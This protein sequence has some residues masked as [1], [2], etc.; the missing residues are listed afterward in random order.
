MKENNNLSFG[1]RVVYIAQSV[2][3]VI[4]LV[5]QAVIAFNAVFTPHHEF[6]DGLVVCIVENIIPVVIFA[7]LFIYA[8]FGLKKDSKL[9]YAIAILN[10]VYATA[11]IESAQA[12]FAVARPILMSLLSIHLGLLT[13]F[14]VLINVN[15]NRALWMMRFA[16]ISKISYHLGHLGIYI[17][18]DRLQISAI[19]EEFVGSERFFLFAKMLIPL[20]ID[21]SIYFC[22]KAKLRHGKGQIT[23]NK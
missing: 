16:I 17:L 13:A 14:V 3:T 15:S 1:A 23:E 5:L 21:T 2:F 9:F 10:I 22:Y 12:F 7:A 19:R 18:Q 6:K 4:G 11:Q 20:L 8:F